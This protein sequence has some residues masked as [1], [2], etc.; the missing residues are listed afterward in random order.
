MKKTFYFLTL[1]AA[2]AFISC[3]KEKTAN[4][5][6][7]ATVKY[8]FTTDKAGNF[9]AEFST[10]STQAGEAIT[11]LTWSKTITINKQAQNN[12]VSF[13]VFAPLEWATTADRANVVIKVSVDGVEKSSN[14][15]LM[16]GLDHAG[17]LTATTNF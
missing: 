6:T 16:G 1:I 7:T 15:A 10:D 17:G 12:S 4:N 11:G 14:S 2:F 8:D 3:S 9:Y 13:T 5:S